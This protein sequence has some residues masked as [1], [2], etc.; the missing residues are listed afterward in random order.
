[1]ISNGDANVAVVHQSNIGEVSPVVGGVEVVKERPSTNRLFHM[2]L[3]EEFL[4][5]FDNRSVAFEIY[6][7]WDALE[8]KVANLP[9][10][11]PLPYHMKTCLLD[12]RQH[13]IMQFNQK[14]HVSLT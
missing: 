11:A 5:T 3:P 12:C 7:H 4:D 9:N 14:A 10:V 2:E 6:A 8:T 1:M 13:L